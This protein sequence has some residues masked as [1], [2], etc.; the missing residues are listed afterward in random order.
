MGQGPAFD[1]V[2]VVLNSMAQLG[3]EVGADS[4]LMR[5]MVLHLDRQIESTLEALRK[6]VGAGNF[7][8]GF[9]AAHG[10]P[11]SHAKHI[12]G[13]TVAQAAGA[14]AV[15]RVRCVEGEAPVCGCVTCTPSCT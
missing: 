10:A 14:R 9:T 12:N 1:F 5:E 13:A 3:Y 8:V 6:Q 15:V 4:P 2:T 7:G 11:G